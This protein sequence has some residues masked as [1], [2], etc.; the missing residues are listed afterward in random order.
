MFCSNA[1]EPGP[2][3]A[4][5]DDDAYREVAKENQARIK[6][7]FATLVRR[8][9]AKLEGRNIDLSAFHIYILTL[10]QPGYFIAGCASISETFVSITRNRL[11]DFLHYTPI[12]QIVKEFGD[13][14]PELS[15]IVKKYRAELAGYKAMTKITEHIKLCRNSEEIADPDECLYLA[16]YDRKYCRRLS[17]KLQVPVTDKSLDY[18]DQLWRSI[19]EY[20]CVP[21]LSVLLDTVRDGCIEVTWCVPTLSAMQIE[22]NILD[23]KEFLQ[24]L[25]VTRVMLDKELLY[26]ESL[27]EHDEELDQVYM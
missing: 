24:S 21:S 18:I 17:V 16:R 8:V 9:T 25:N 5:G 26:D 6:G 14:D 7:S 23:S 13:E 10:F 3:P 22:T 20:F 12:E 4:A 1:I 27:Y 19:A 15:D 11:W 2:G